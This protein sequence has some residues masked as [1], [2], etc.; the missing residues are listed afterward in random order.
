[1]ALRLGGITNDEDKFSQVLV[2]LESDVLM[3][4]GDLANNPPTMDKFNILKDRI[5]QSFAQTTEARLRRMFRGDESV[6]KKPTEILAHIKNLASG[7]CNAT[8]LRTIFLEKL[9]EQM[10]VLL[11]MCEH[12]DLDKVAE[13]ADKIYEMSNTSSCAIASSQEQA[14]VQA[15]AN[16]E[17]P[18]SEVFKLIKTLSNKV[19][20]L[21]REYRSRSRSRSKSRGCSNSPSNNLCFYHRRFGYNARKC[22]ETC[23]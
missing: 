10:R 6:G 13:M 1:M 4:V 20:K 8:V 9:P 16:H 7:E 3:L 23:S 18:I 19:D 21:R 5:L 17:S 11:A 22:L 2:N 14:S 12:E 15:I